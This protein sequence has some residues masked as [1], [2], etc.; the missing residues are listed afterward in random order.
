MKKEKKAP[1]L[2]KKAKG[3]RNW[4]SSHNFTKQLGLNHDLQALY[5]DLYDL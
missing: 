4:S 2:K 3:E 1:F 5:D